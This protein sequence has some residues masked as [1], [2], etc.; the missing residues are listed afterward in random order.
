[1]VSRVEARGRPQRPEG[2]IEVD[3]A[4]LS[5]SR[6]ASTTPDWSRASFAAAALGA[7]DGDDASVAATILVGGAA[8][9][10]SHRA[11]DRPRAAY[12]GRDG[13]EITL[14]DH[15]PDPGTECVVGTDVSTRRR[16]K[17][18][19]RDGRDTRSDSA[20]PTPSRGRQLS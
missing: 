17:T 1:M 20:A 11:T 7:E 12:G 13:M 10:F 3:D 9:L 15:L 14:V 18:T 4:H 19:P 2:E 6:S 8:R 5:L 16:S